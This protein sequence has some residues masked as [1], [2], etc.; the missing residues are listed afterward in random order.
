MGPAWLRL[1]RGF[2]RTATRGGHLGMYR[3]L[4]ETARSAVPRGRGSVMAGPG[5]QTGH[6]T[7][8][9]DGS[10]APWRRDLFTGSCRVVS[11]HVVMLL[12]TSTRRPLVFPHRRD[13]G[14]QGRNCPSVL[15]CSCT[16]CKWQGVHV[17]PAGAKMASK[18]CETSLLCW[19]SLD[20]PT[21]MGPM[22]AC[23]QAFSVPPPFQIPS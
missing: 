4:V 8:G 2:G 15:S 12:E 6:E 18:A 20:R 5:R 17:L 9:R 10:Q 23:P 3:R 19:S 11:G 13:R 1:W 22:Y 21:P 7:D 14:S 16:W